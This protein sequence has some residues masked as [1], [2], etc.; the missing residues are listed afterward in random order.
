MNSVTEEQ[1][2]RVLAILANGSGT[3]GE[4]TDLFNFGPELDQIAANVKAI[5]TGQIQ[6]NNL[7]NSVYT[8]QN[9]AF[10]NFTQQLGTINTTLS[11]MVQLLQAIGIKLTQEVTLL[12][13]QIKLIEELTARLPVSIGIDTSVTATE[14]QQAP[15]E[16]GP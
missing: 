15:I 14:P 4:G 16:K 1:R 12:S 11:Q 9:T 13:Q 5:I 3:F 6:A 7:I 2:A 10:M 8:Q